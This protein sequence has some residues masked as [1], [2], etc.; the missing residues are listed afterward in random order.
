MN[1]DDSELVL[2]PSWIF[3]GNIEFSLKKTFL[4]HCIK[5]EKKISVNHN[6]SEM[7]LTAI[8]DFLEIDIYQP[9]KVCIVLEAYFGSV[10]RA[11]LRPIFV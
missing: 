10:Y 9:S 1:Y 3:Y 11:N 8:W 7:G 6:D 2:Q 4:S 5:F